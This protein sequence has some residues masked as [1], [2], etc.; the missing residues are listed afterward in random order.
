MGDN[1]THILENEI[2]P[3]KN[4]MKLYDDINDVF[5]DLIP[6]LSILFSAIGTFEALSK[7]IASKIG[8]DIV[9]VLVAIP[10]VLLVI[11][12]TFNFSGRANWTSGYVNSLSRIE[13]GIRYSGV[14]AADASSALILLREEMDK[15]WDEEIK[16]K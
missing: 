10:A 1:E 6:W 14:S 2:L 13:A 16:G 9:A 12:K 7:Y 11:Q 8:T 5:T 4:R 15:R 3:L